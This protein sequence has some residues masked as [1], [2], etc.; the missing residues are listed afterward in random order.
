MKIRKFVVDCDADVVL[1]ILHNL[2]LRSLFQNDNVHFSPFT[3]KWFNFL[4]TL[5]NQLTHESNNNNNNNNNNN[6]YNP[7]KNNSSLRHKWSHTVQIKILRKCLD[8]FRCILKSSLLLSFFNLEPQNNTKNNHTC[9]D[10]FLDEI[11]QRVTPSD[12]ITTVLGFSDPCMCSLTITH[13]HK[14]TIPLHTQFNFSNIIT[15][16]L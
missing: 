6:T 5:F 3:I 9:N 2:K 1:G 11:K 15:L 12:M 10:N 8:I 13:S 14:N 16:T 4:F 7:I